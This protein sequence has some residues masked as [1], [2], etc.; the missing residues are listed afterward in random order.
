MKGFFRRLGMAAKL[1]LGFGLV[2]VLLLGLGGYSMYH[3]SALAAGTVAIEDGQMPRVEEAIELKYALSRLRSREYQ[4]L[5]ADTPQE[6]QQA[7]DRIREARDLY[8]QHVENFRQLIASDEGKKL[9]AGFEAS[10]ARYLQDYER[11]EGLLQDNKTADAR[12]L[13]TGNSRQIYQSAESQLEKIAD[14]NTRDAKS[15]IAAMADSNRVAD[16][17]LVV[18][19]VAS[20]IIAVLIGWLISRTLLR[21][22]GG[23]PT[24]ATDC[25][26]RIAQGD[27]SEKIQVNGEPDSLLAAMMAMQD[28]LR[29]LIAEINHMSVEHDKG[30]IDVIIDTAKFSGAFGDM[31]KGIN[32]MVNGHISV[33]KKAMS[34]V[35]EFGD[36]NFEAPLEKFPG[37]KVFI[38][39]II[40]QVRGNLRAL[41]AD[42]QM[43]AAAAND[44]RIQERADAS[45][46]RGD[47]RRIVE[48]I[49]E[50]LETIVAPIITVKAAAETVNSA[51]NEIASGNADL[52]VRTEQQASNLEETASSMEQLTSTV[53]QNSENARQANQLAMTASGVA[54]KGGTV[55][56]N[57][58]STMSAINDSARKI[59]DI[60]S[61]IDGIAFQTNILALNA[62]VEAAR[63]G[64]QGRGFAVV[65]AEVRNLAQRS[66]SAA[67][68]IKVLIT[69]SVDKVDDGNKLVGEAGA[70]MQEIVQSI[71]RVTDL[72]SEIAAASEEQSSGIE[73]INTAVTQ[74]DEMTQQNAALVEEAS[75][76]AEA[77][78]EQADTLSQAMS[79]F[80]L[81]TESVGRPMVRALPVTGGGTSRPKRLMKS[82]GAAAAA[83]AARAGDDEW[84]E[85]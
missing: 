36:G 79:V 41:I 34:V 83:T 40:E 66:A 9:F 49:N 68:E 1:Q 50:T 65:A 21:Q 16:S 73:Q 25:V 30:D 84:D 82:A 4:L 38:N 20:V 52:S 19:I 32:D 12:A 23:E 67:K 17:M 70:T 22:L 57:V 3:F 53:R 63:A 58:V 46:H 29:G 69:D 45:R 61:V 43:L 35:K 72:M 14:L 54:E 71:K 64:E 51:A 59:A 81:K 76:S 77:L 15:D 27:L 56:Q 55:V 78:R 37:K 26:N 39:E 62:A 33:K 10:M 75:A 28:E 8:S 31:A 5:I 48:G 80:K 60:I 6:M 13:M 24:Y 7:R 18:G 44:G 2:I 74:M 85:F 42:T 47:F 11:F